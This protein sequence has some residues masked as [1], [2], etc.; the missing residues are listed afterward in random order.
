MGGSSTTVEAPKPSNEETQLMQQQLEILKQSRAE[1]ELIKP[2]VMQSM[3]LTQ[4][5]TPEGV[6]SYRRLT[7]EERLASMTPVEKSAYEALGLQQER[8]I[9][10]LKGLLPVSP[11]LESEIEK[12][13]LDLKEDLSRRLGSNW[14][15]TTSGTQASSEFDKKAGLLR[16][17][18]RRGEINTGTGLMLSQ[19]GYMGANQQ[20]QQG[21]YTGYGQRLF[22][23]TEAYGQA[24]QPYQYYAGLMNRANI[25]NAQS[26]SA[27]SAGLLGGLGSLAGAGASIYGS[28][29]IAGAL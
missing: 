28:T 15:L 14:Q 11:A 24:Q 2:Y 19:M 22:P 12:S 16:E 6:T 7:E 1:Q 23:L 9:K 5:T 21:A 26:S 4:E 8:Q 3:G 10:A 20:A 27:G 18:A 29:V 17:E 13:G 25:A